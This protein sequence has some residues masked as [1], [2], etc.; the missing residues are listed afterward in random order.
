MSLSIS[1]YDH[2]ERAQRIFFNWLGRENLCQS[3]GRNKSVKEAVQHADVVTTLTPTTEAL[4]VLDLP[5][6]CHINAVVD[7]TGKRVDG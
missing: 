2:D 5:D 3:W 6:R 7:A 1:L 4:N